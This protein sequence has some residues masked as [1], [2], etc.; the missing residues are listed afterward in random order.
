MKKLAAIISTTLLFASSAAVAEVYV[1]GKI[2]KSWLDDACQ[3]GQPCDKD[4]TTLGAFVGYEANKWLSLEA[5]YDYLGKFTAAGLADEKVK[6]ITLAPKLSLPLTEGI[7]LYGKVGGAFVDY[8][9]KD[10]YSY[11]GAAGLEFN[12]NHNVTMRLEY[13]NITDI[14]NDIVRASGESAT[15][16][17]VYKFGG[18]QEPAPVVEQ[19]PAEPAPVAEPVVEKVAVTK[20]F[21]FQHLDSSTFATASAEL[22]PATVKKLDKIV[23]YLNQYPQAKVEVVGHTD[24]T[25]SDAYNQKLSERRAQAVAKALEAQGIDASRIS[26]KGLG[27]SSPIASNATAEGREKNR[28]V[29]LVIPEFQYQ[30]TE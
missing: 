3:S 16:G 12:T 19:R 20:T 26:A 14:N 21:T 29:E 30:V 24:S 6:A 11:L 13:Q 8:G 10:D 4:D 1:G 18:S 7:A 15:L 5:G 22:K 2:G 28:R 23:G 17:V 25:G 9:S 27:E